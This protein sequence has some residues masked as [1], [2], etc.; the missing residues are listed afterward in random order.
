MVD[1]ATAASTAAV[2]RMSAVSA[3]LRHAGLAFARSMVCATTQWSDI[4]R[5]QLPVA[6]HTVALREL[7]ASTGNR[8]HHKQLVLG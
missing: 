6:A 1:G 7:H 4:F 3:P 8:A 5:E 2:D